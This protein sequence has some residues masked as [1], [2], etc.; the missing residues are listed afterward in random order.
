MLKQLEVFR[1]HSI[2]L[3]AHSMNLNFHCSRVILS[4]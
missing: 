3:S 4:F 1:S 2:C